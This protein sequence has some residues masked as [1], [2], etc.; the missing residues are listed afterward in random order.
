M[1]K[2]NDMGALNELF[3]AI[4][5]LETVEECNDFFRD[6]CTKLELRSIAQRYQV[7]KMLTEHCVYNEIV[8]AT[9]ASTATI[10][11]VNRSLDDGGNGYRVVFERL[12]NLKGDGKDG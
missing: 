1:E 10:S 8:A 11:R 3:E 6:V 5:C 12:E 2:K 4:L 7:A 9:G